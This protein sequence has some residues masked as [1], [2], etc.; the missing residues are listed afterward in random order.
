[1]TVQETIALGWS[2]YQSGDLEVAEETYQRL[3]Q[4]HP[5][6]ADAWCF[7]GIVRRARGDPAG[8]L[9]S[10]REAVRLRPDF[11]EAQNNLA[12]V[13]VLMGKPEEALPC[14][15]HVLRLRPDYAD[16]HNNLGVALRHLGRFNEAVPCY[17]EALRLRPDHADAHNNLGDALSRLGQLHEAVAHYRH[18]LRLKPN[19]PA[20]YNNLG[21]ALRHLGQ[22]AEA[23]DC[24]R[25]ALGLQPGYAEA[26]YN[27]GNV[28]NEQG[29]LEDAVSSYREAVRLKPDYVEAHFHLGQ[30]LRAQGQRDAALATYRRLL[31]LRPDN[32]E[33]H[34]SRALTWLLLSDYEQGWPE[35]ER[36]LQ[37]KDFFHPPW[38]R[39]RWDGGP[40][41]GRTI[42]LHAEQGL[43]DTLQF[44]RY[45]PLV[46]ARGGTVILAC[47][48][49]LLPLLDGCPGVDRLVP[50]DEESPAFD[51]HAALP[52]LPALFGTTLATV[53]AR[54][55]YLS[56]DP[57]LVTHWRRELA[58]YPGLK[59]GIA[60]QGNPKHLADRY[61]SFPLMAFAPLAG[62]SRVH[63]FS[64]QKGPGA[65]R[66]RAAAFP[67]LDLGPLLDEATGP[68][69]DTAAVMK[70]FDLVV[71]V[72]TS[73]A[74]L[75][76]ALG[77]TAWVVLSGNSDH[78]WL[79]DR[80]DSPWY[81][82]LRLFRQEAGDRGAVFTRMAAALRER[83]AGP[84]PTPSPSP[85]GG[86][87]EQGNCLT[88]P[89]PLMAEGGRGGEGAAP[90]LIDIAPGELIDK[91]TILEIKRERI[92]DPE[93]LR[94]VRR[95]LE[96]LAAARAGAVPPSDELARLT[97]ELKA[98]NETLWQVEDDMRL[99][100]RAG[101]FGP[102][103][104]EL[105]RSVYRNN[106][107]RAALKRRLNDLLGSEIVEE[108]GY[109][110]DPP[111]ERRG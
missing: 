32:P 77:V 43:G 22:P 76:G 71:T 55:P 94:N 7:L 70:N 68:F 9:A 4:A 19:F 99:C 101:D 100:E 30:A 74:H 57:T 91:I 34:L 62:V 21:A 88:L 61:R 27:L 79:L 81:P 14:Y 87:G 5:D 73:L 36:R 59:V 10:Y 80:A 58:V 35:Y 3:V 12:N 42:L 64:L 40:L 84:P 107:R 38:P 105:A 93:K 51:V 86:G 2:H 24:Y 109:A 26:H 78:R 48:K 45:A 75:A 66:V 44:V 67:V 65:E 33:A 31:Q 54:V 97:A 104:V 1:M 110:T 96:L 16:A 102:R 28:C 92:T 18:A 108:K 37:C 63:L 103:F 50:G 69:L 11:V 83:V 89:S 13:L 72:D 41:A 39:P 111:G 23:A 56:A 53:P 29:R 20:A 98:A 25:Q 85:T 106:D 17:R 52:S 8:A 46:Q 82:T 47:Q 90:L 49:P 15:E 95:E 60:W 6:S